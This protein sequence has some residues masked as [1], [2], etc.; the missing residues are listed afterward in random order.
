M[1]FGST[2][3]PE[4]TIVVDNQQIEAAICESEI[5]G[6][7]HAGDERWHENGTSVPRVVLACSWHRAENSVK[8]QRFIAALRNP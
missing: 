7:G 3:S 4:K 1:S 5:A 2:D 8:V 6:S